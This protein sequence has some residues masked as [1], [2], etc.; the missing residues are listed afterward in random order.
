MLLWDCEKV[1][2]APEIPTQV[3]VI[4]G[5]DIHLWAVARRATLQRDQESLFCATLRLPGFSV[6]R[7]RHIIRLEEYFGG[8]LYW[9]NIKA[10]S[11]R[12]T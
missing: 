3:S 12:W 9:R 1:A 8:S 5:A 4:H 11:R 2:M 7:I 6:V 10:V